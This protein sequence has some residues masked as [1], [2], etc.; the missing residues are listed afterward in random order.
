MLKGPQLVDVHRA[1]G[2][3]PV[4]T[5]F[6]GH[7]YGTTGV[8]NLH[9]PEWPWA[10][11][12]AE[13]SLLNKKRVIQMLFVVVLE[14]FICWTPLYVINTM[15]LFEPGIVYNNLT[16]TEISFF[17]LLAY[18]SSCCNPIT[19]CFMNRGF[20]KAFL[21]LFRCF[22]RLRE[23]RR[24]SLGGGGMGF[25]GGIGGPDQR[26]EAETTKLHN[27]HRLCTDSSY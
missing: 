11:S 26:S 12:N 4:E 21:N 10:L 9:V 16:S 7:S 15:V 8:K 3:N 5:V 27:N 19:Y 17:H 22:K 24:I 20:R 25:G 2:T 1:V 13:K 14:F 23:P 18:T 6:P